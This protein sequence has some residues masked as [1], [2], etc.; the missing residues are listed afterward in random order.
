MRWE[1]ASPEK[2]LF[3]VDGKSAWFYAPAD[4]TVSRV[5]VKDSADWRT[6][7]A[8][9]AGEMRVSR[10][11]A[12]VSLAAQQPKDSSFAQLDCAIRGTEKEA[13]ARK[14]HDSAYFVV[15]KE[16]GELA[17][18]VVVGAGGVRMEMRF[19][20]WRFNPPVEEALFH[21]QPP[22][23]VTIVD[24]NSLMAGPETGLR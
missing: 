18:V 11:C 12:K 1:Y 9:L 16:T 4:R 15:A 8:L 7:L 24:G 6:P 3:V 22:K 20:H 5:A 13:R 17:Q 2:N 10:V 21:F 19:T 23:G 14:P